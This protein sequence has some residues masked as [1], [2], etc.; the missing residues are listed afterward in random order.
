M[1]SIT[2]EEVEKEA[3]AAAQHLIARNIGHFKIYGIPRGGIVPAYAVARAIETLGSTTDI[4]DAPEK[5]NVIIDDIIDSGKTRA[6]YQEVNP[7]AAFVALFNAEDF[8]GWLVFPW[9]GTEEGS[10][11]D[12]P[13]RL[14]QFVGEDPGRGG[15][16]ETPKRFLK[17]WKFWTKGYGENPADV[18]KVF[19]DGAE[20]C[21]EMVLVKSI[22]IYSQC[23]HHLAPFFGVAH[24]AYIPNGKI[25]GLSKLSRLADVFARRLQVQERLTN[26]IADAMMKHLDALGV[27]VVVDCRHMC[28]ESR[29]IQRHGSSTLTSAMRGVFKEDAKARAE[30]MGLIKG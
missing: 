2:I 20:K 18:L 5:A 7:D 3:F 13:T 12:I 26:E 9:E 14:L 21:D 4:V 6:R 27:A 10:A 19:E 30:F 17:A 28:M 1:K 23:E 22:P 29:G 8:N 15:L 11:E 24:I 16:H 25:V